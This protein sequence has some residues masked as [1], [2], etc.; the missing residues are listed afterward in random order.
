MCRGLFLGNNDK[1]IENFVQNSSELKLLAKGD[2]TEIML[3]RINTGEFF[4]VEPGDNSEL[5]EF[6]YIL[7][8]CIE[9][10]KDEKNS[11]QVLYLEVEK[12]SQE[13][14]SYE[15][16][17]HLRIALPY[18]L[19]S[20]IEHLIYPIFMPRNEEEVLKNIIILSQQLKFVED[21]PQLIISYD[22]QTSKELVFTIILVRLLKKN[23]PPLKEIFLT[24]QTFLKFHPEEVKIIGTLKRKYPKESNLF[25]VSLNKTNFYR[26]K[27]SI[28]NNIIKKIKKEKEF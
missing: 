10:D 16:I 1:Y 2:G 4:I 22:N 15:E 13:D 25:K 11:L 18:N 20:H 21:L 27:K 12:E 9:Y 26:R 6:F 17:Q 14:F 19:K 5:L 24:S 3:Q 28:L 7:E 8:G 23:T